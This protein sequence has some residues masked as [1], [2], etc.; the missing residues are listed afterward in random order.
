MASKQK[1]E[2]EPVEETEAEAAKRIK[3][4]AKKA[5]K[6]E[7]KRIAAEKA[8]AAEQTNLRLKLEREQKFT[9]L[10]YEKAAQNWEDM[11]IKIKDGELKSELEVYKKNL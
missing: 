1:G 11:M 9:A 7:K 5:A 8:F 3:L 2:A 10:T 4:A 6:A